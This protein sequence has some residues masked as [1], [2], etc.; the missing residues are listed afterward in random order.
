MV[1]LSEAQTHLV[2]SSKEM[3]AVIAQVGPPQIREPVGDPFSDLARSI[4][5]QQLATS[6]A[7]A[8]HGR[9][10]EALGGAV[11]PSAVLEA[12]DE[13]LRGA[14]LS[15]SKIAS[16]RDLAAKV[17]GGEVRLDDFERLTDD[18]IVERLVTVRGIG[19][20][21]AEMFLIFTMRRGDVWPV[22]DLA[23]RV[24]YARIFGLPE[25]PSQ[26]ELMPLGEMF[27]PYRT[28][29]AWYCWQANTLP[30]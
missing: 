14:G 30:A 17:A 24:G 25:P 8:I 16:L 13:A 2:A 5:F 11:K 27:R 6:A 4:V 1:L 15:R 12:S 10:V 28:T 22:G 19:P 9:V 20:W 18:A 29:A 7:T 23:V 26:K 3:A 21:T